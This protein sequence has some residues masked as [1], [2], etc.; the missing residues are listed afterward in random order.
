MIEIYTNPG[1]G[2][3][4]E[5]QSSAAQLLELFEEKPFWENAEL[6]AKLGWQFSQA[7]FTLRK[8]GLNIT[9]ERLGHRRFG[10]RL[11]K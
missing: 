5:N 6:N 7:V 3:V 4:L 11:N 10:Y 1:K 8:K 9:T 2:T